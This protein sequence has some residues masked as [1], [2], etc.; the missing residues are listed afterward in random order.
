MGPVFLLAGFYC[1]PA[2]GDRLMVT[3]AI[4]KAIFGMVRAIASL[5]PA[6]PDLPESV[7]LV[8]ASVDSWFPWS[9]LVAVLSLVGIF[10]SALLG[11]FVTNWIIKRFRGG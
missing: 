6:M 4:L 10:Y 11:A 8:I 5:F 1:Y 9:D 7:A 2:A 3:E